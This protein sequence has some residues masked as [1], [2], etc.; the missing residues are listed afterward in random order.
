MTSVDYLV[1]GGGMTADAAVKALARSDPQGSVTLVSQE[2]TAPYRRPP[3]SKGLWKGQDLSSIDMRTSGTGAHLL[4][5]ARATH[6]D[7]NSRTVLT[8]TG[9]QIHYQRVLLATGAKPRVLSSVP[10]SDRVIYF[11]TLADYHTASELTAKGGTVLVVGGG[12]IGCELA[13]ALT[14]AGAGVTMV[15]PEPHIGGGRFPQSLSELIREDYELR[16][17]TVI[18]GRT[19]TGIE[20][21]SGPVRVTLSDG[22]WLTPDLVLVGAG[23]VAN[24]D[25][26]A[27]AGLL[28]S[29]GV[30]VDQ[31]LRAGT[32][33]G[34]LD[35]VFAAGDVAVHEWTALGRRMRIEHEDNAYSMGSAA[36]RQMVAAQHGSAL[37]VF[38]HLPFFYS[39]LFDNGFEAVGLLDSSLRV[40]EDWR[41]AGREGVVYYLEGSFV[42]GVLLW[43]TWG[44]IDAARDLVENSA[45]FTDEQLIGRLPEDD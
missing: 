9:Q 43:N 29:D 45:E 3:L 30:V 13:A 10:S 15:F 28:T 21:R 17:V 33:S 22:T 25:L 27:S 14:L 34:P 1:V 40:L 19:V 38:S 41:V 32:H 42:R 31:N 36:A 35:T 4:L 16:G 37:G 26:A 23:T 11:R 6:L 44:Q 8:S 12:F 20:D 39:D 5:G 24:D 7:V 18:P 2:P